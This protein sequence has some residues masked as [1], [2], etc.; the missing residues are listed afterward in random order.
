MRLI[1][2]FCIL[3]RNRNIFYGGVNLLSYNADEAERSKCLWINGLHKLALFLPE[4][5]FRR[6]RARFELPGAV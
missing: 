4:C 2:Y 1:G 3:K 6:L 5:I